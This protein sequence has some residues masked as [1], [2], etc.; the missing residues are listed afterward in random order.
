ME[1]YGLY[2]G[3]GVM[4][5]YRP[6]IFRDYE[7]QPYGS[8]EANANPIKGYYD[9]VQEKKQKAQ[10]QL[11]KSKKAACP[12][13]KEQKKRPLGSYLRKRAMDKRG[14]SVI[15]EEEHEHHDQK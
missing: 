5:S 7:K 6:N 3:E 15:E 8:L 4:N 14:D 12:F 11:Q 10:E 9:T 2:V 13:C 1:V